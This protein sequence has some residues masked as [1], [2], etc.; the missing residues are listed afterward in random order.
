MKKAILATMLAI[1]AA[2]P[3]ADTVRTNTVYVVSN[4]YF[5]VTS[6][7]NYTVYRTNFNYETVNI[8]LNMT[9]D[10]NTHR[11]HVAADGT[12][13]TNL[14]IY[15][16]GN[17]NGYLRVSAPGPSTNGLDCATAGFYLGLD[18][19][20]SETND[21]ERKIFY[22]TPGYVDSDSDGMRVHYI[23][24]RSKNFIS[25]DAAVTSLWKSLELRD[26]YWAKGYYVAKIS[27]SGQV[28][29]F[30]SKKLNSQFI[31]DPNECLQ[32]FPY[33]VGYRVGANYWNDDRL[34]M[35]FIDDDLAPNNYNRLQV[36]FRSVMITRS[37]LWFPR[38][39]ESALEGF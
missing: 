31:D 4:I 1:A 24:C 35:D 29:E 37:P 11:A 6:I 14:M 25:W 39:D 34:K 10:P 33:Y 19:K 7:T 8:D 22:L 15:P 17:E 30:V 38:K 26:F 32:P 12:V 5:Y 23:P 28:M 20:M 3:A 36:H 18:L 16:N 27:V 21:S 9:K 13:Y 2:S